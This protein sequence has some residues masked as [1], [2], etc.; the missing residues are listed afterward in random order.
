MKKYLMTVILILALLTASV[1]V[2]VGCQDEVAPGAAPSSVVPRVTATYDL[3]KASKQWRHL[4]M[5]GSIYTDNGTLTLPQDQSDTL[6][7]L[8]GDTFTST[9]LTSPTMS[10]PTITGTPV[11]ANRASGSA[12][13]PSDGGPSVTVAHGLGGTP[14]LVLLS[15]GGDSGGEAALIA[16]SLG[17]TDFTVTSSTANVTGDTLFYWL[18]Y[19]AFE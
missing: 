13:T 19:L 1:G 3:G 5:T 10:D 17:G 6:A 2:L 14:V 8:A 9:S 11:V 4:Q 12:N 16:S 18:A 7:T 15:W